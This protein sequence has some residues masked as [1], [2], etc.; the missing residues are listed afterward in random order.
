MSQDYEQ[1][2]V[3]R[4][5]TAL[6]YLSIISWPE[7]RGQGWPRATLVCLAEKILI[8]LIYKWAHFGVTNGIP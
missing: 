6:F 8:P 2:R 1:K 7:D 5:G 4:E 3:A